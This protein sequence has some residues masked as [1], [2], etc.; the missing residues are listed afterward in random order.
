MLELA[1]SLCRNCIKFKFSAEDIG[2]SQEMEVKY[3]LKEF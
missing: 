3:F 1:E 2:L